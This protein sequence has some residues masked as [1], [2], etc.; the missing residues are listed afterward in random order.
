MSQDASPPARRRDPEGRRRAIVQ[1]ALEVVVELG[2]ER[3][4]HRVIAARAGVPLGATT[5]YFPTLR[6]LVAAAMDAAAAEERAELAQW[7]ERIGD[8]SDLPARLT[9]LASSYLVDRDR[10]RLD[11]ELYVAAARTPELRPVARIWLDGTREHLAGL[12]GPTAARSVAALLDGAL[13]QAIVTGGDLDAGELE[14]ALAALLGGAVGTGGGRPDH[15]GG[16]VVRA[17]HS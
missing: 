5:Y 17:A 8:G 12:V 1:A 10:A 6:D 3:T 15:V 4:T 11:Y 16:P 7:L 9:A 13:L 2:V 14:G